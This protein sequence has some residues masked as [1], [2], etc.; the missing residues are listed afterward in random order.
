M[1]SDEDK[2]S[3]KTYVNAIYNF[4]VEKFFILDYL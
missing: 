1:K 4:L 2:L 3:I